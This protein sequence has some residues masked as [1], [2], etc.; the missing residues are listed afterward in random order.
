MQA[1]CPV[2]TLVVDSVDLDCAVL[3]WEECL[4]ADA[5]AE[6]RQKIVQIRIWLLRK[7]IMTPHWGLT[8][9]GK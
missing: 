8:G 5:P 7:R 9:K 6:T 1:F 3:D 4:A 2:S